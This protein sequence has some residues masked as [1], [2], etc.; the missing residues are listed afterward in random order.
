M[1]NI[2]LLSILSI[3]ICFGTT[4]A[5][6][7]TNNTAPYNS[8]SY[9]VNDVL[10]GQGVTAANIT[11]TGNA[12]Q[13]GFFNNG[14]NGAPALGLDSGIVISSGKIVDIPVGGNQPSNDFTGGGDPDLLTIAQ[15]VRPGITSTHDAAALEFDFTP[16]G[17]SVEFRFVFASDE[18]L[19]YINT[20]YND[21]FAFFVSG[22]GINGTFASPAGFPNGAVNIAQVPGTTDP[23]TISTI[24]DDPTETPPQVNG[25]YFINNPNGANNDFNGFTT[26]I[27]IKYG[28]QCG[29]TYHFKLAIADCG[30]GTLD[31]G[32]FLE[33]ASFSS[34]VV[35][36]DVT[37][38]TGDSTIIEGCGNAI[39]NFAR[40]DS[41][42]DHTVHFDIG[43]NAINGTD[44]NQIADS[45]TFLAG[46]YN[47]SLTIV[48]IADGLVEGQDTLTITVYTINPC[49][50]T[51]VSIGTLYIL[52]IPNLITN[53]P[54]STL[55]CPLT[56]LPI[57]V[58]ASGAVE[59]FTYDWTD[60][61][62]NP[63]GTNN[64]TITVSGMVTDT[65]Y[66]S[67]T[68]SCN[69][70]TVTDT[71]I[72]NV[73]TTPLEFASI[74]PDSTIHCG[75][76]ITL[77]ATATGGS[78]GYSYSWAPAGPLVSPQQTTT[79]TVTITDVCNVTTDSTVIITVDTIPVLITTSNDTT[80]Y[81]PNQPVTLSASAT[82]GT[83][84]YVYAWTP[85]GSGANINVAPS[86]TTTY[87]VTAQAGCGAFAVD[88]VT[89]TVNSS[90]PTITTSPDTTLPCPGN[91]SFDLF[92]TPNNGT[93]PYTYSWTGSTDIDSLITVTGNSAQTITVTMTDACNVSVNNTISISYAPYTPMSVT[94]LPVDSVCAGENTN[95][96]ASI[97]DGVPPYSISWNNGTSSFSGNPTTYSSTT[98]GINNVVVTVSDQCGQ[99]TTDNVDVLVIACEITTPNVFTP[100]G[101][102]FNQNLVFENL[103]FFPNNH[104]TIFNRW[105]AKVF[106]QDQ[107]Q[108]DWNGGSS[109][110]GTYF[111]IIE[112]NNHDNKVHK[113]TFTIFK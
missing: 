66:V 101:D 1:K 90:L 58:A 99:Q 9:L 56:N 35:E 69:L 76:V 25:Q 37:T 97:A 20:D 47:T 29:E 6:I 28:V 70:I 43:G 93:A 80:I 72:I 81:C 54:D 87:Y 2:Y 27:T 11:F 82:D 108:N 91:Y 39:I 83:S 46:N 96:T 23:I 67:V 15:T 109:S 100:N 89:V 45:V 48:P 34:E 26:V 51:I 64:D 50:D 16:Q 62:G 31:T 4:K 17:D 73:N 110:D 111:Y 3:F 77:T 7:G 95:L 41:T 10:L 103:E 75:D 40:P 14:N 61:N 52:D 92:A 94:A 21:I 33:G 60:V 12:D 8:A 102:E 53:A 98:T 49:G 19:T 59:P 57:Y 68:D 86:Q 88:S 22:P 79:Y 55:A 38:A 112:L 36:V 78:P 5:Q 65:F 105:G 104:I 44:Y 30:D 107:Y 24:Y 32:V 85:G 71:V 18:Y 42:G 113:G 106:E 74:F 63:I 13:L 84:L